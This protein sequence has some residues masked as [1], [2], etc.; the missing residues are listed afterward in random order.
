MRR[1][2]EYARTRVDS[3]GL[4]FISNLALSH[5]SLTLVS[6]LSPATLGGA[7]AGLG[8]GDVGDLVAP[9][10][11]TVVASPVASPLLVVE[12][13]S[14]LVLEFVYSTIRFLLC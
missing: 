13:T 3:I 7:G 11:L 14:P 10:A 6:Q 2:T 8:G 12:S 1:T 5:V 4:I 9:T